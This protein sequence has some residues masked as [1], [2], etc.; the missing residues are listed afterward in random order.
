MA[1]L[2]QRVGRL[3]IEA[4]AE[5]DVSPFEALLR[6]IV[7]QQLS[8]KAAGSIH[9]R[10][11][12]L[13]R[14][15]VTPRKILN[16]DDQTLRAAGLSRNK[17]LAVQDLSR[18]TLDGTVPS[19]EELLS[20]SDDD[21][22]ERLSTVRGIGRWTVEMML[23]FKLGRP[24]VLPVADLGVRKGYHLAYNTADLP[25]AAELTKAGEAWSPYRSVASWYLW[26]ATDLVDWVTHPPIE[27]KR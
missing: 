5:F 3:T 14:G 7:Y 19:L 26:R 9:A 12:T 23:I 25:S 17:V 16:K 18:R 27:V 11:L 4:E 8:G 10:V 15:G 20:L 1:D 24:D 21:I 13:C 22:V 6:A 2:M